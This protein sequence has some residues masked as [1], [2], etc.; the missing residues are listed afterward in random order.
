MIRIAILG[1]IVTGGVLK[2]RSDFVLSEQLSRYL[3][4][5][6]L[7]VGTLESPYG[8]IT[9]QSGIK[10]NIVFSPVDTFNILELLKVDVVS[11]A[12]NHIFDLSTNG[13]KQTIDLLT[14][15]GMKHCG[16]GTNLEDA[17]KPAILDVNN[18]RL[19]F[20]AYCNRNATL[21]KFEEATQD[22]KGVA[23][24]DLETLKLNVRELRKECDYVI[25]LIHWGIEYTWLVT[26][27]IQ[28]TASQILDT[29]VDAI[30]G[31]HTHRV[32]PYCKI[33]QKPVYFSLGNF[34]FP[35]FL[36]DPP[37]T[38]S[39]PE[40][41]DLSMISELPTSRKYQT[42]ERRTLRVWPLLSRIGMIAE[43]SIDDRSM[44]TKNRYVYLTRNQSRLVL[45]PLAL[46]KVID[47]W[48]SLIGLCARSSLYRRLFYK[49]F[50]SLA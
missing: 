2:Y 43:I 19:G 29:G 39:Y 4:R 22:T 13:F 20:L 8:D 41:F 30:I 15:S 28:S 24:L 36:I 21:S 35:N 33:K 16:A 6:D 23:P 31:S 48:L 17:S 46:S 45:V 34:L 26:P 7:R 37:L 38:I 47:L 1:D 12:N 32:Q 10:D 5:F 40:F 11:L 14:K 9:S 50:K 3:R 25:L 44:T 49:V 27:S 18:I 42:I